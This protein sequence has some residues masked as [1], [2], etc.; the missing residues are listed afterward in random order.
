ML[1]TASSANV[2]CSLVTLVSETNLKARST[3]MVVFWGFLIAAS[4]TSPKRLNA[5]AAPGPIVPAQSQEQSPAQSPQPAA[6][7]KQPQVPARTTLDGPWKLNRD[8]SDDPRQRVRAAEGSSSGNTSGY[9]GGGNT[10]GYGGI[11][12]AAV[13]AVIPTPG[14]E[15][16]D[17][18][19]DNEIPDRTLKTTPKC[20][21]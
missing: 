20:S 5:Q 12:V 19:E 8:E 18:T 16:E 6:K 7:P 4:L 13:G 9:P 11:P 2:R 3:P 15:V 21:R 14:A 1:G 10:G 17:P